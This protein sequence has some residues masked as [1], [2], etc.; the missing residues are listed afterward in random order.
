MPD[1]TRNT[2]SVKEVQPE[3]ELFFSR[4]YPKKNRDG[5]L[6]ENQ[7]LLVFKLFGDE[8]DDDAPTGFI[9]LQD[10][11]DSKVLSQYIGVREYSKAIDCDIVV[12]SIPFLLTLDDIPPSRT[13]KGTNQQGEEVVKEYYTLQG[14]DSILHCEDVPQG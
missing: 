10:A 9:T 12:N 3:G 4:I 6:S 8:E 11:L 5:S 1:K 13:G 7:H 14:A 2:R